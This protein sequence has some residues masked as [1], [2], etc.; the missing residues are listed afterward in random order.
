MKKGFTL[1]EVLT[2]VALL[3]VIGLFMASGYLGMVQLNQKTIVE[4]RNLHEA[5]ELFAHKDYS[6]MANY[7]SMPTVTFK[8]NGT[9]KVMKINGYQDKKTGLVIYKIP[10]MDWSQ[11]DE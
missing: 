10:K 1:V 9:Q 2:A 4:R 3:V 11:L 5:S 6:S 7:G 8:I